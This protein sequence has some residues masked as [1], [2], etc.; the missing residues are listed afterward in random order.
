MSY[1]IVLASVPQKFLDKLDDNLFGRIMKKLETLKT[2][3]FPSD[4]KRVIGRKEKVFRVRVGNY[5][6][7]YVVF[8]D[9]KQILVTDIDRRESVYD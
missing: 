4:V 9:N 6:V 2:N 1:N 8:E 7:L 5:R 3:S